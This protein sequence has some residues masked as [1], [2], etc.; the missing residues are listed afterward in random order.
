MLAYW[1]KVDEKWQIYQDHRAGIVKKAMLAY[2]SKAHGE[3]LM[4]LD[5]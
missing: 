5:Y 3:C 2:W 4:D 1:S